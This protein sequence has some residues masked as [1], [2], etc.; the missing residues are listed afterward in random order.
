MKSGSLALAVFLLLGMATCR[1]RA[2]TEVETEVEL[3]GEEIVDRNN[4][5][6]NWT[7]SMGPICIFNNTDKVNAAS[8]LF[9]VFYYYYSLRS[10][11]VCARSSLARIRQLKKKGKKICG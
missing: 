5:H 1:A 10:L 7:V 9:L 4:S 8:I 2:E 3:E 6:C 11:F